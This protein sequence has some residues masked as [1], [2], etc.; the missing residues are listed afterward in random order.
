MEDSLTE[1]HYLYFAYGSNMLRSQMSER[2]P[3]S[4]YV[5]NATLHGFRLGFPIT[6][7]NRGG[8]G[9]A[10]VLKSAPT[11]S[12]EGVV[13]TLSEE[14]VLTLDR[15]EA[16]GTQYS[17]EWGYVEITQSNGSTLSEEKVFYYLAISDGTPHYLP[18]SEYL[19]CLVQ[20]AKEH[21]LGAQY[22]AL[23]ENIETG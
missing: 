17:R 15:F 2:C 7:V 11:D 16:L 20:G 13:Y 21:G 9:V 22:V 3:S 18:S 14:D 23:L 10:S 5:G 8:M 4:D 19:Y 6:S 1:S 12:V